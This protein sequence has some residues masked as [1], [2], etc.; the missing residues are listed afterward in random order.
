MCRIEATNQL[1]ISGP[2]C[3]FAFTSLVDNKSFN[4]FFGWEDDEK[5]DPE[6]GIPRPVP[7][8]L[9]NKWFWQGLISFLF[10]KDGV[11]A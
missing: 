5:G 2:H 6:N 9:S 4:F 8:Y 7:A 3:E 1:G 11:A 10:S